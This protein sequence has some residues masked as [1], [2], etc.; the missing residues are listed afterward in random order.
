MTVVLCGIGCDTTNAGQVAPLY[1]D[2]RFEYIPIPEKTPETEETTTYGTWDLRRGGVAADR[3]SA[4]TPDPSGGTTIRGDTLRDWPLHHDPN[5]E[6]LTYG[7]HRPNYLRRL[8]RLDPG[9]VVGL[10]AG[11]RPPGGERAHR[12]LIGYFTVSAVDVIPPDASRE[13]A[14]AVFDGHPENAHTKRARAGG[15]YYDEETV[16]IVDGC[17]PGGLFE[18]DPIRMST[19]EVKPGNERAQYYLDP[20]FADRFGVTEGRENMQF[21]PAYLCDLDGR[22]FIEDAGLPEK[23]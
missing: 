2:G 3:L 4:I 1:P 22:T 23:R 19:Y 9:D 5:F 15:R 16:V 13:E 6:A 11:L 8:R 21:K 17:E 18:R 20:G 10:Y 12:Y 14:T 7:E